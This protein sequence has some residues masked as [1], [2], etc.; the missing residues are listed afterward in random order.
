[1]QADPLGLVDGASVYGYAGQNPGRFIDQNGLEVR[2]YSSTAF[3]TPGINHAFV[4]GTECECGAG[5]NRSSPSDSGA[6]Q[7]FGVGDR[8]GNY[9]VMSV[10]PGTNE[11]DLIANI[12]ERL[13]RSI[14]L[15]YFNDCHAQ[16]RSAIESLGYQYPGAPNNRF[17]LDDN[18]AAALFGLHQYY[19]QR[20]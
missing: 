2:I 12:R 16:L 13:D 11:A 3:G 10:P 1:M 17:D 6:A 5:T 7:G 15:P 8:S 9:N 4:Y 14:Y 18:I 20:R 19:T